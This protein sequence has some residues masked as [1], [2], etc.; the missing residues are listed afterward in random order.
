MLERLITRG[1]DIDA[2]CHAR[3]ILV[4]DFPDA[5]R[6]LENILTD[7]D[8]RIE[9]LAEGGGGEASI[10]QRLRRALTATGWNTET[11][12]ITK[13]ID[14]REV[15]ATSHRIDHVKRSENGTIAL[16]IEWNNKDPFFDR[17][18]ENFKR[19]HTEDAISVGV[20]ITR[21]VSLQNQ[22]YELLLEYA[23]DNEINSFEV[24]EE[25]GIRRTPRQIQNIR[26]DLQ[27]RTFQEAWVLHFVRDK[28][29]T[30]TTHWNKLQERIR[31]G[32]GHPCPLL[33]IGIPSSIVLR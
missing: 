33:M 21:G 11:F 28:F 26:N 27:N 2:R 10:T 31:R 30:A 22:F 32:V 14:G 3:A 29:G 16:E 12:T 24:L 6:D 20:V 4:G 7:F 5:L 13:S 23:V 25:A 19:L 17:D 9:E 1:F 8:I 15:E 18:L